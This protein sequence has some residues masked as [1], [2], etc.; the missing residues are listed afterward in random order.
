MGI[1]FLCS[2]KVD[3]GISLVNSFFPENYFLYQVVNVML[4]CL[5]FY[6][7]LLFIFFSNCRESGQGYCG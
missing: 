5:I 4:I 2:K 1:F 7:F 3:M 6:Y